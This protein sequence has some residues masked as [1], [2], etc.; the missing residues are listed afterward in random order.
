MRVQKAA[1]AGFRRVREENIG[2]RRVGI[3]RHKTQT[4]LL[5]FMSQPPWTGPPLALPSAPCSW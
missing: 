1:R 2:A 5:A 4:V 3:A